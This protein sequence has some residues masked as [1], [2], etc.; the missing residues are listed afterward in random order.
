VI[1]SF[2]PRKCWQTPSEQ[3]TRRSDI[4]RLAGYAGPWALAK[5]H[6][7]ARAESPPVEVVAAAY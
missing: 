4:F 7:N 6:R 5:K 1:R 3:Q 2:P